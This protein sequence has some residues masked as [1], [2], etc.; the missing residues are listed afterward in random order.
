MA[1]G[2]QLSQVVEILQ[3]EIRSS[4][5][6]SRG[7]DNREFLK[8]MVRRTQEVLYEDYVWPFLVAE[9]A[10]SRKTLAAGQR[11]YDFPT[12]INRDRVI[13]VH[14]QFGASIWTTIEQGIGPEE[15]TAID[16]DSDARADPALRWDFHGDE[17]FEVWP[18]PAS[19]GGVIW[20]RAMLPLTALTSD[21]DVVML[22]DRAI[23]LRAAAEILAADGQKDAQAKLTQAQQRVA[24]LLG[25]TSSKQRVV[26]G[27]GPGD[28]GRRQTALRVSY[29]R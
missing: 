25:N 11:Y 21:A 12:A 19:N 1:R 18:L 29:V 4:T 3:H 23:A 26:L 9:K 22:D 16:S 2:R 20:F 17:Q 6:T 27:G 7:V 5:S 15:Y 14:S 24:K 13:D 28:S 10:D 8:E